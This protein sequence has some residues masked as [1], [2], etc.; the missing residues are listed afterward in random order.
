VS[1]ILKIRALSIETIGLTSFFTVEI[2]AFVLTGFIAK[3]IEISGLNGFD[4]KEILNFG[5]TGLI[6]NLQEIFDAKPSCN[7][8]CFSNFFLCFV[9]SGLNNLGLRHQ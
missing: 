1:K 8:N 9:R 5:L 7:T 4:S 2:E 6:C 3:K